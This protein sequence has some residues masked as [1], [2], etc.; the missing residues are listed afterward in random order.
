MG[1]LSRAGPGHLVRR[2][3]AAGSRIVGWMEGTAAADA[4]EE[5]TGRCIGAV[6]RRSVVA[7]R[8]SRPAGVDR[9]TRFGASRQPGAG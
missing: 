1:L 3:G 8:N 4:E 2:R 9:V 5:H 7:G 6:R